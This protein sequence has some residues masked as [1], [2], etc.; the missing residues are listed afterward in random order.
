[1]IKALSSLRSRPV[2]PLFVGTMALA[3]LGADCDGRK[4]IRRHFD[5]PV[6]VTINP[7]GVESPAHLHAFVSDP[8]NVAIRRIDLE[9]RRV[10]E[11][12]LPVGRTLGPLASHVGGGGVV[13]LLWGVDTQKGALVSIDPGA[14]LTPTVSAV[15][16]ADMGAV[17]PLELVDLTVVPGRTGTQA[18]TVTYREGLERWEV[19][20]SGSGTQREL[21]P[22]TGGY[23]SDDKEIR[24]SIRRTGD[25]LPTEGDTFTFSTD[26]GVQV[27]A[28][29]GTGLAVNLIAVNDQVG[30]VSTAAPA[31]TTFD[32]GTGALIAT[33]P[34]PAGAIP[35]GMDVSPDGSAA[36]IADLGN[37]L[38]HRLNTVGPAATWVLE[39]LPAEVPMRDV[40]VGGD[41]SRTFAM[42][43][44]ADAVFVYLTPGWTPLDFVGGEVGFDPVPFP[45]AIRRIAS[46]RLP[47]VMRGTGVPSYPVFVTTHAGNV[48]TLNGGTGCLDFA[49][50]RGAR[51]GGL[52]FRDSSQPSGPQFVAESFNV[53]NCGGVTRNETFTLVYNGLID[54][55]EITGTLSGKQ[56][57]VLLEGQTYTTDRGEVTM[58]I[59]GN[60]DLPSDDG[61]TF[62]LTVS[63]GV[64]PLPLGLIP[65]RPH[66]FS[67]T[68]DDG[69]EIEYALVPNVAS[70]TLSQVEVGRRRVVATYR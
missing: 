53:N 62:F 21:A 27:S 63:D 47:V 61:D 14:A 32:L 57:G 64:A 19:T 15:S 9:R 44:D 41:G 20:G 5:A 22:P 16:F 34:L 43:A 4:K 56:S 1:M 13:D 59:Q 51:I 45:S 12:R 68:R 2:L 30:L 46:A 33:Y 17:S 42:A 18:W 67:L 50:S 7:Y 31:L 70:D 8:G 36:Y 66:F 54:A 58:L 28:V 26:N 40:A 24:F 23:T 10:V 60:P 25:G 39:T 37:P 49:S 55:W 6:G 3:L 11:P 69:I 65:D 52:R 35:G 48:F 38:V 29:I